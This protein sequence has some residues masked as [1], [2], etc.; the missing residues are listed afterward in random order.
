MI[1]KNLD[2]Y[3]NTKNSTKIENIDFYYGSENGNV[4]YFVHDDYG[5]NLKFINADDKTAT[6]SYIAGK[7]TT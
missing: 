3:K 4:Y 5:Y 6:L 2:E 1:W 7:F